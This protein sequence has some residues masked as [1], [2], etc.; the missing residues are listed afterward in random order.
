MASL[1]KL[2]HDKGRGF[3]ASALPARLKGT[4]VG[5]A[6]RGYLLAG[7]GVAGALV[8]VVSLLTWLSPASDKASPFK[9]VDHFFPGVIQQVDTKMTT[10]LGVDKDPTLT[11]VHTALASARESLGSDLRPANASPLAPSLSDTHPTFTTSGASIPTPEEPTPP[12]RSVASPSA[13]EAVLPP[14]TSELTTPPPV[15]S[16]PTP[17]P[18]IEKPSTPPTTGPPPPG[19]P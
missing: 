15:T 2:I 7:A 1:L 13:T 17:P 3:Y 4:R 6:S 12:K 5:R 16:E 19:T 14:T 10:L 18:T 11:S 8:A 9:V